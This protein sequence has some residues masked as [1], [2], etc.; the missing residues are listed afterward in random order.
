MKNEAVRQGRRM[1]KQGLTE[2]FREALAQPPLPIKEQENKNK[3]AQAVLE[4]AMYGLGRSLGRTSQL[5]DVFLL[6][7]E[8][9][10]KQ[11]PLPVQRLPLTDER[12][13]AIHASLFQGPFDP[14]DIL[15]M[16]VAARAVEAV[17]WENLK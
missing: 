16:R 10:L 12:L 13:D 9:A 5:T 14:E 6:G 7:V 3:A 17:V 2:V 11:P 8:W 15:N 4:R 1:G